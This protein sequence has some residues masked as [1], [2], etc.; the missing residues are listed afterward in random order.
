MDIYLIRHTKIDVESG[1]C[2]GQ[3]DVDLSRSFPEESKKVLSKLPVSVEDSVIYS[4]PLSRCRKLASLL[5]TTNIHFDERLKELDFGN[6]ELEK[7]DKI[8]SK[9]LQKWM[10]D[11]VNVNCPGGESYLELTKRVT[12]WWEEIIQKDHE[13]VV[14]I[15]HAGVI[16]CLLSYVLEV[17]YKNS[18]RLSIDPGNISAISVSGRR[19]SVKYINR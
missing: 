8:D 2:Y 13:E 9:K 3:S 4:S 7:W 12:E 10:D 19:Y 16:R 11:F 1:T 18:F 15:T 6:W 17:P 5:D 14:V